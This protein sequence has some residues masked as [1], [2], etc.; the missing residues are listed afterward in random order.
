[1]SNT[2]RETLKRSRFLVTFVRAIRAGMEEYND[3]SRKKKSCREREKVIRSYL[4]SHQIK[5]LQIGAGTTLLEGWL[6]TDIRPLRREIIFLDAT[7]PFPFENDTFDYVFSEHMIEHISY[8][9]GLSML[10][11]CQRVL[12]PS[13][14]IRIATPNIENIVGLYSRQESEFDQE[15][16]KWAIDRFMKDT[17]SYH[18]SFVVNNFFRGFGHQFIYDPVT[19]QD[20]MEKVGFI[21]V[22]RYTPGESDDK[23]LCGIESHGQVIGDVR[24]QFETMVLEAKSPG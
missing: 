19:L 11:E 15:Y 24:N 14:K 12:K 5:M 13:G 10:Q 21:Q 2:F 20:A 22:K 8:D 1:M 9:D 3:E 17:K 16:I 6:S 7:E 18:K 23:I 4:E